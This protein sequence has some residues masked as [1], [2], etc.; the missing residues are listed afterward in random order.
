MTQHT[1]TLSIKH[2]TLTGVELDMT[3]LASDLL[4]DQDGDYCTNVYNYSIDAGELGYVEVDLTD[5]EVDVNDLLNDIKA[6]AQNM[7]VDVDRYFDLSDCEVEAQ[8]TLQ[9]V[10]EAYCE[11]HEVTGSQYI[12][13]VVEE[14]VQSV[15]EAAAQKYLD[16]GK[17]SRKLFD[18]AMEE[19][20]EERASFA[21]KERD[22]V[23]FRNDL[24]WAVGVMSNMQLSD[25]AQERIRGIL[26]VMN[27]TSETD[28]SE[29]VTPMD[30]EEVA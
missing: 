23:R 2:P 10:R 29:E 3:S 25:E 27:E 5:V 15:R 6:D 13:A 18:G 4:K 22:L 30:T 9:S 8:V 16:Q 24:L 20:D 12:G 1:F 7:T 19:I 28:E 14:Y 21:K 11:Q 17:E 26:S